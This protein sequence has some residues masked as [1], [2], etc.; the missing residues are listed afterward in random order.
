MGSTPAFEMI[1]ERHS[2]RIMA[3]LSKR[4]VQKGSPEDTL[5]EVF[6]KLHRSKHLYE[7]NL[8]FLPWL[9]SITRSVMLD[10]LKKRNLEDAVELEELDRLEAKIPESDLSQSPD[11]ILKLLPEAQRNVVTMRVLHEQTFEEIASKLSTSPENARQIFSR[12]IKKM[13]TAFARKEDK[14][15]SK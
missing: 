10:S 3:F 7:K 8:P 13:R 6:L 1:F 12:G 5:Q 9:F 14:D 11:E 15:G 4:M 2:S